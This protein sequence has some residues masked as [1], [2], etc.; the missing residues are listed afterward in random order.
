LLGFACLLFLLF[1]IS[2]LT[3]DDSSHDYDNNSPVRN[4]FSN[5][6]K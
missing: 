4:I 2:F 6:G 5:S 3:S 1:L